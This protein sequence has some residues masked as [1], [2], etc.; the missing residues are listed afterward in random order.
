MA[1]IPIRWLR[2][3][4]AGLFRGFGKTYLYATNATIS[5]NSEIAPMPLGFRVYQGNGF[6]WSQV[7]ATGG[8]P[9]ISPALTRI[10]EL[11]GGITLPRRIKRIAI[12]PC[13]G[14]TDVAFGSMGMDTRIN[15]IDRALNFVAAITTTKSRRLLE[16]NRF[17]GASRFHAGQPELASWRGR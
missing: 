11:I 5:S 9:T 2:L 7:P 15:R 4:R 3:G 13:V 14:Q 16:R 10:F 12:Y 8:S 17:E 1:T 6:V